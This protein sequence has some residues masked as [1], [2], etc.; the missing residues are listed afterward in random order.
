MQ[1]WCLNVSSAKA[2]LIEMSIWRRL[3]K[4]GAETSSCLETTFKCCFNLRGREYLH[5]LKLIK[6]SIRCLLSFSQS[7]LNNTCKAETKCKKNTLS[8]PKSCVST[9]HYFVNIV[10]I[11]IT[12]YRAIFHPLQKQTWKW[13]II[14]VN[15]NNNLVFFNLTW[16]NSKDSCLTC[17]YYD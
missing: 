17:F 2:D 1:G 5:F 3:N 14:L 4:F 13:D 9:W 6:V 10:A 11:F 16:L 7:V 15:S 12:Q 8:W